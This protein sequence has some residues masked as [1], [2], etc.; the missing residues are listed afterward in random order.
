MSWIPGC[1][2]KNRIVTAPFTGKF[3]SQ[4]Q[5]PSFVGDSIT[6][7][8]KLHVSDDTA[9][10]EDG[11]LVPWSLNVDLAS[12]PRQPESRQPPR[13]Q[14]HRSLA[15]QPGH[16]NPDH[17]RFNGVGRVSRSDGS[18]ICQF[19]IGLPPTA[20][21]KPARCSTGSMAADATAQPASGL[22][23]QHPPSAAGHPAR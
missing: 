17:P 18:A 4:G 2:A 23:G 8:W 14:R 1:L 19:G 13:Q 3:P 9:N 7:P 20:I 5:L 22:L 12:D 6:G 16:R 11:S 15:G 10:G 21:L